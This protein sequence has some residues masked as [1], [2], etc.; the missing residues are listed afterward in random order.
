[1]YG[2]AWS[3]DTL[4]AR[5]KAI[6]LEIEEQTGER[7]H[8]EYNW[9]ACAASNPNY[10]QFVEEEI[11]RLGK[12]HIAIQTQYLLQSINAAGHFFNDLQRT[13]LAGQHLWETEP[14]PEPNIC[15]VA[16]LDIGGEERA[17]P[18]DPEKTNI[19]RDS[20][21]MTIARMQDNEMHLP[22]LEIVHQTWWTGKTYPEQYA[23][24]LAL[25]EH[26]DIR[27]LV[28]DNTG[29]GAGLASMLIEKLGDERVGAY[30]F[31]R[32]GKSR[33]GYQLLA[34]VN[35]GRCK[36]YSQQGAPSEIYQECWQQ[37]RKARY[38]LPAPETINF[39]VA[40][41]EGHDDFLI[42]LSL[43]TEA[44]EGIIQPAASAWVRPKRLYEDEGRY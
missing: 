2:T 21:V 22:S 10:R 4:L 29:Q 12:E 42:S 14:D 27:R 13:L 5:Q 38:A 3:D 16:G 40:P 32:P 28:I 8:F 9:H 36:L 39:Y 25:C 15:Y 19:K 35:S 43:C 34:L 17:N 6:N 11:K 44:L 37:I 33:L 1:M 18:N 30:T 26:W 23:A 7:R 24:V 41:G 20:T 31:T